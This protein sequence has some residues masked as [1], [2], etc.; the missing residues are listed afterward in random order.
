MEKPIYPQDTV[1]KEKEEPKNTKYCPECGGKVC[2][3]CGK[4]NCECK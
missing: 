2:V 4:A 1:K 3:K